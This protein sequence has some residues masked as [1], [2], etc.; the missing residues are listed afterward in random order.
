MKNRWN[1]EEAKPAS[2]TD[3][4][5]RVYSSRL[6]GQEADLVLH[7]GGN[8]SVKSTVIDIFSTPQ[9]ILYVKGSGWDLKTIEAAGYSPARLDY[10]QSLATLPE[11][12]DIQMM[13][14]LR[15]S[16]L[17]PNAPTP[18][19]EAILHAIIPLKFVDHTHAD[20]VVSISNNALGEEYLRQIY[21]DEIL[22]LPYIMPG[23]VLAKQIYQ[24]TRGIDWNNIKGIILLNHG[25]FTF[26][27][28]AKTSYD[29]MIDIVSAAEAFLEQKG[30]LQAQATTSYTAA[31]NDYIALAAYRKKAADIIGHPM[32][33]RWDRS[34]AAVGFASIDGIEDIATRGPLTPDHS[35]HVKGFAAIIDPARDDSLENFQRDYGKYFAH[36]ADDSQCCLDKAPRYG[37]WIGRGM[38]YF[39]ANLKRLKM[40][41]DITQHTMKAIQW[42]QALG[43]WQALSQQEIFAVEYWELEQAK[44]KK[45]QP[46]AGSGGAD[47]EG[48]IV[49]V[50][51]A[52]SGIGKACVEEFVGQ[53]ACVIALD[54]NSK[55]EKQFTSQNILG[56]KCDVT[57]SDSIN[58]A[59]RQGL[60][61]FG[62]IDVIVS[63]AGSFPP[64][65]NLVN[66]EDNEWHKIID[67][68]LTAHMKVIR[69]G[70][71]F[72]VYGMDPAIIIVASKNVAAPG[73]G[74][75]A[76]SAA[77]AGL[78]QLARVAALEFGAQG[79]RVNI[80][81]PN[82]VFDTGIWTQ[83]VLENR[84]ASYQLSVD[85]YKTNNVLKVTV[86][87]QDVARMATLMAGD[88]FSKTTGAQVPVD[89]GN[90]RVI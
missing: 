43:G 82:A 81:H 60:E 89:G 64:C 20:A 12:N 41:A 18:S 15:V 29:N 78:T 2:V 42:G 30:A 70:S 74:A 79:V 83:E 3:L 21:G 1:E 80:L 56:I 27:D 48:K 72:L 44:L 50:T 65:Q 59:V 90:V 7:G 76:Y 16:L 33:L 39:A 25:V 26:A 57:D 71:P 69:A 6:L 24:A 46:L 77:K 88:G 37:V 28:D 34:S 47:Y 14:Q 86:S 36:Y 67:L 51:G 38:L 32:L 19:V 10:L 73:P 61:S 55:I 4:D 23:F 85:E 13:K 49:L 8:T 52:A 62:G 5:M 68:N 75:S 87:A 63:N 11:L 66:I 22:I 9:E 31:E 84:A 35:I 58:R 45:A 53:G 40:V 17:E 54:I